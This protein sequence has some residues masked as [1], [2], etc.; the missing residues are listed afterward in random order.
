M[1]A[2]TGKVG[3]VDGN[4]NIA[5]FSSP[6]DVKIDIRDG[7]LFVAD[8]GNNRIHK[9]SK[10]GIF[11]YF[12]SKCEIRYY[13]G[14]VTTVTWPHGNNMNSSITNPRALAFDQQTRTCYVAHDYQI[15][16][17]YFP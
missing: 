16:K 1:V 17:L 7:S 10:Q 4:S 15:S 5:S 11:Y 2:G 14:E 9:I 13:T 8:Y 12:L 3:V 6:F